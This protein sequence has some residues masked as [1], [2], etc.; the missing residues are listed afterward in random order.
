MIRALITVS[1]THLTFGDFRIKQ[2]TSCFTFRA[3]ATTTRSE[4]KLNVQKFSRDLPCI[5]FDTFAERIGV[6]FPA[7]Y[8]G[9]RIFPH[10]CHFNV[11]YLLVPDDVVNGKTFLSRDKVLF[12]P[13]DILA[14]KQ[15]FDDSCPCCGRRCV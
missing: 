12:L 13:D 8:F 1:Y 3:N 5:H 7:F 10:P 11:C 2:D 4:R 6:H 14:G 15:C 9:K